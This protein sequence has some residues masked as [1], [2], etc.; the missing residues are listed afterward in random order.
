LVTF[1]SAKSS[2]N[3]PA[4]TMKVKPITSIMRDIIR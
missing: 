2:V 3:R 4:V 1:E